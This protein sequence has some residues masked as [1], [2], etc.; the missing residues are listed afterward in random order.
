M[1]GNAKKKLIRGNI[2]AAKSGTMKQTEVY[3]K[4]KKHGFDFL[5]IKYRRG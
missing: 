3:H 2:N 4:M 5:N 1:L